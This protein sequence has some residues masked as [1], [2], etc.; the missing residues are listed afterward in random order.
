[1]TRSLYIFSFALV[2]AGVI[3]GLRALPAPKT[4]DHVSG[5]VHVVSGDTI[6]VHGD[7]YRDS[8]TVS[9]F[10]INSVGLEQICQ[11]KDQSNY[12]CGYAAFGALYD[13]AVG[14]PV[15][16]QRLDT[17]KHKHMVAFCVLDDGEIDLA[18]SMVRRGWA[19]VDRR[20]AEIDPGRILRYLKAEGLARSEK[21]G[22]WVG[23]FEDPESFHRRNFKQ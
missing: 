21:I 20:Y 7:D 22:L 13:I 6:R 17:D 11:R 1:M 23:T 10:G 5:Y 9:L 14:H 18:E 8:V 3:A 16:C 19:I 2:G 15:S 12:K 4:P